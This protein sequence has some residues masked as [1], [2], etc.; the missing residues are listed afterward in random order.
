MKLI[1]NFVNKVGNDKMLHFL[2]G[3]LITS[4]ITFIVLIQENLTSFETLLAVIPAAIITAFVAVI[5]EKLDDVF[6]KKDFIATVLG[7]IPTVICILVGVIFNI[8]S[9]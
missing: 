8:L 1:D 9:K 7:I 6:N 4:C 3:N 5:K 2:V